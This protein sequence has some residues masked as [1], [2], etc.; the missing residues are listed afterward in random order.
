MKAFSIS[1]KLGHRFFTTYNTT[2]YPRLIKISNALTSDLA[3]VDTSWA[4]MNRDRESAANM[5]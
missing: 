3:T 4:R 5:T 2:P 1:N